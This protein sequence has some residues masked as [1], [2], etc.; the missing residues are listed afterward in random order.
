MRVVWVLQLTLRTPGLHLPARPI[1]Q[2]NA[3]S[4]QIPSVQPKVPAASHLNQHPTC[5]YYVSVVTSHLPPIWG[6]PSPH[7][8][9]VRIPFLGRSKGQETSIRSIVTSVTEQQHP[10][11]AEQAP[12]AT[13]RTP[14]PTSTL[15]A[16]EQ[17]LAPPGPWEMEFQPHCYFRHLDPH[18]SDGL[19][20]GSGFEYL[21]NKVCPGQ[22]QGHLSSQLMLKPQRNA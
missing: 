22:V 14:T 2:P 1:S 12:R 16:R 4:S 6:N 7:L 18:G 20:L 21:K 9:S 15:L 8:S 17:C 10:N 5:R 19:L 13:L 11:K 3:L